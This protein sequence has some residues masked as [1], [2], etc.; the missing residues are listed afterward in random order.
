VQGGAFTSKIHLDR[1]DLLEWDR[2]SPEIRAFLEEGSEDVELDEIV[3]DYRAEWK[4]IRRAAMRSSW[5]FTAPSAR[6]G[7]S[8]RPTRRPAGRTPDSPDVTLSFVRI[9]SPRRCGPSELVERERQAQTGAVSPG[10]RDRQL[11]RTAEQ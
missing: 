6:S 10:V 11:A 2:W 4:L 7:R 1:D 9:E 8:E 3:R 5:R